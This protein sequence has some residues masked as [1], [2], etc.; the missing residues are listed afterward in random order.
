MG[1]TVTMCASCT[2]GCVYHIIAPL[3]LWCKSAQFLQDTLVNC[4]TATDSIVINILITLCTYLCAQRFVFGHI[5]LYVS[6]HDQ[7]TGCL[8]SYQS[9]IP[10]YASST[11]AD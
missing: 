5:S 9:E 2:G 3:L 4:T 6:L 1:K 10:L 11:A 8:G 7:K